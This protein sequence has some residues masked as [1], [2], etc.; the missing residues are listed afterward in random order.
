MTKKIKISLISLL[1]LLM[2]VCTV[3]LLLPHNAYAATTDTTETL[4]TNGFKFNPGASI[5]L[6][7]DNDNNVFASGQNT[8][9]FE[10][11]VTDSTKTNVLGLNTKYPSKKVWPETSKMTPLLDTFTY[12]FTLYR[13][14][15]D[16]K[17]AAPLSEWTIN[18]RYLY[19]GTSS[20]YVKY[21]I[22]KRELSYG[23]QIARITGLAPYTKTYS[24]EEAKKHFDWGNYEF[25]SAGW[26]KHGN[27]FSV[28]E[29]IRIQV[30]VDSPYSS[31]F[32]QFGY[33]Y[34]L[35]SQNNFLGVEYEDVRKGSC[36]SDVRSMSGIL[37][38]MQEAGDLEDVLFS[39][40]NIN[41]AYN[42][43]ENVQTTRIRVKYLERV[44][45]TPF[46]THVAATSSTQVP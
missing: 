5:K 31:Y 12:T 34:K 20:T 1:S 11:L 13:D 35:C 9:S 25:V 8:I 43:L 6:T 18:A 23:T 38:N 29:I 36:R 7:D 21:V 17:T 45:N 24:K 28:D 15:G 44:G 27:I 33:K 37:K 10:F 30:D 41:Y 46:A 2:V 26:I 39:E 40:E 3:L 22:V 14:N 19:T 42:I 4:A 16:G 32:V